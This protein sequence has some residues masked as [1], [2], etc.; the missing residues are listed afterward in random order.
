MRATLLADPSVGLQGDILRILG[1]FEIRGMRRRPY[2][3]ASLIDPLRALCH[4]R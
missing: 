4:L 2:Q 3:T 1:G